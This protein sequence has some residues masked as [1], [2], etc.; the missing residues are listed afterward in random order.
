[1]HRPRI[2]ARKLPLHYRISRA[3]KR[4]DT[5]GM[6]NYRREEIAAQMAQWARDEEDKKEALAVID[7]FNARLEAG[8]EPW[9][10]P[11]IRAALI[12]GHPWLIVVCRSC[13]LVLD[14]DLRMKPR[15]PQATIE[16]VL[17]D[18]QCPRCN[19]HGR[20]EILKLAQGPRRR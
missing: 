8:R 16:M 7:Y 9:F 19:G 3:Q 4:T 13:D 17:R 15:P 1:M 10:R 11:T 14:V 18:V 6:N 2:A 12:A 20:P 5:M